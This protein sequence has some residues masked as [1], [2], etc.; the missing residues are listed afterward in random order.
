MGQFSQA[1]GFSHD[2]DTSRR[3][4]RRRFTGRWVIEYWVIGR[5][6]IEHED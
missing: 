3:N 4:A 6:V 1:L 5:W 2:S